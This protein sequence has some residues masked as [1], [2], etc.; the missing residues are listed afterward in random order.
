MASIPERRLRCARPWR[1]SIGELHPRC[2]SGLTV[3]GI[4]AGV[5]MPKVMA[6]AAAARSMTAIVVGAGFAFASGL[7][8]IALPGVSQVHDVAELVGWCGVLHLD[9]HGVVVERW[10]PSRAPSPEALE[11]RGPERS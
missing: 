9:D 4:G 10:T 8:L 1:T 5:L 6:P 3:A 7:V 2:A 11:E